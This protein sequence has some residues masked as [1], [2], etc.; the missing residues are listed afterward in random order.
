MHLTV[1]KTFRHAKHSPEPKGQGSS[2]DIAPE[3]K[4]IGTL[5]NNNVCHVGN[6]IQKGFVY[7]KAF[8]WFCATFKPLPRK[9]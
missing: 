5:L 9:L 8:I 1:K 3:D 4:T 7:D 2:L 6:L